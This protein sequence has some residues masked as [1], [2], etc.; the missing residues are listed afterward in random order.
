MTKQ[1]CDLCE[2]P[3][4]KHPPSIRVQ[5]PEKTWRGSKSTPGAP[6]VCDGSWTPFMDVRIV[7]DMNNTRNSCGSYFPDICSN[8]AAKLIRQL[9]DSLNPGDL[10]AV[11]PLVPVPACILEDVV[12]PGQTET[13]S[14][15]GSGS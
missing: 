7:F 12:D 3:A 5:F 4:I 15:A 14:T 11:P 8:C 9:A 6:G 1:F 13:R 10:G 2:Q